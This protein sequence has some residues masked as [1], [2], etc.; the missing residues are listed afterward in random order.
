MN[1]LNFVDIVFTGYGAIIGVAIFSLLP[2]ITK[3]SG[4]RVWFAFLI[5]GIIS[6]L[7]GLTYGRLNLDVAENDAEYSWI[8]DAFSKPETKNNKTYNKYIKI[9]ANVIVWAIIL[10]GITT[11]S[12]IVVS[13]TKFI[14]NY[15]NNY[16]NNIPDTIKNLGLIVI[17]T[18]INMFGVKMMSS[19]NILFT[20]LVTIGFIILIGI[21]GKSHK[22][23][24]ELS[25]HSNDMS[26]LLRG[27][28][29]TILPFNG[30]QTIVNMSG[31]IKNKSLIPKGILAASGLATLS[32]VGVAAATVAILGVKNTINSSSPVALAYGKVFGHY[33][34]DI[35]NGLAICNGI[36]TLLIFLFSRANIITSLAEK[37]QVPKI[38]KKINITLICVSVITYLFTLVPGDNLEI[39]ATLSNGLAFSVFAVINIALLYKYHTNKWNNPVDKEND[40]TFTLKFKEMYP[41]Y[42]IISLVVAI[43]LLV[44]MFMV[45]K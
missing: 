26:S 40:D 37:E 34:K 3:Y 14:N 35:I 44:R 10:L 25:L 33:G 31:N 30:F 29:L 2:Y 1:D 21:S 20:S 27:I 22:Y 45:P 4:G 19:I 28:F 38:F 11:T 5:G 36:P 15:S 6:I 41:F 7:T 24:K 43:I 32:Y 13:I 23:V 17:P 42:S 18:I 16:S 9:F 8:V 12:T 39:L